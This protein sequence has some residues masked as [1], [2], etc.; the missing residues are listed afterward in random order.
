[1]ESVKTNTYEIIDTNR[2]SP[3]RQKASFC[4]QKIKEESYTWRRNDSKHEL[5]ILKI[6]IPTSY[7]LTKQ[8][9]ETGFLYSV[10]LRSGHYWTFSNRVGGCT[11]DKLDLY[12]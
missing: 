7:F 11:V 12:S 10:I 1:M 4:K 9:A 2:V 6:Q 3:E 5:I 8:P